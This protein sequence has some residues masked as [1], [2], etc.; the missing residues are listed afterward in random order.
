MRNLESALLIFISFEAVLEIFVRENYSCHSYKQHFNL[1]IAQLRLQIAKY[2]GC[3]LLYSNISL[4]FP[5]HVHCFIF[6]LKAI[7]ATITARMMHKPTHKNLLICV[8]K[9]VTFYSFANTYISLLLV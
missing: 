5:N 3:S 6:F 8:F 1:K 7:T 2:S 4:S 9:Q